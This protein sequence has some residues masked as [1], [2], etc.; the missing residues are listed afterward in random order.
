MEPETLVLNLGAQ[1]AAALVV[2]T[3]T[4][5]GLSATA[6]TRTAAQADIE[7]SASGRLWSDMKQRWLPANG[8]EG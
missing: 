5:C 3:A 7:R 8:R 1:A 6:R 2:L 4:R